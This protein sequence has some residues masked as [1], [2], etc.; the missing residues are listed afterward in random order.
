M[1]KRVVLRFDDSWSDRL[2]GHAT[3]PAV[4]WL[5]VLALLAF[6][7]AA[8]HVGSRLLS[9]RAEV[10]RLEPLVG[11]AQAA[12]APPVVPPVRKQT[13][14]ERQSLEQRNAVVN[15]LNTPW[16]DVLDALESRASPD[17]GLTL[18]EPDGDKGVVR[19][20]A[21]AKSIDTLL[22]Y[23]DDFAR[24]PG[25]AGVSMRQHDTNEQ[26]ANRPARLTFEV[27]LLDAR[28]PLGPLK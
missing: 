23:A 24:D 3:R 22:S 11:Q 8:A 28:R 25:F 18:V 9:A 12:F 21:E 2:L 15:L 13:S 19:I 1:V 14:L 5:V 10:V 20:Q 4:R 7:V 26:D 17:V 27:R 6:V 16:A